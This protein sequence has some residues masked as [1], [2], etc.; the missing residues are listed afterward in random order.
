MDKQ[1]WETP[2]LKE[3]GK[4]EDLIKNADVDGSGDSIFPVNL[5]SV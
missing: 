2:I 1:I 5:E 3:I 4:A